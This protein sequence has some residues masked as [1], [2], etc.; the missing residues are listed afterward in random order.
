MPTTYAH[1][2]FGIKVLKELNKEL[3]ESIKNNIDL[4]NIGLHGPDILFYYK[5]L[6][7]N[8]INMLGS[9]IHETNADIFFENSRRTILKSDDFN[10]AFA[11]IAGFICHYVLDSECHP[12][13]RQKESTVS[14]N[15][16]ETEFDREIMIKDNL[17]PITFKPTSHITPSYENAKCISEFFP[18]TLTE[19][20]LKSLKS[21]KF[22]LNALV[23]PN[24]AVRALLTGALKI[25]GNRSKA[26]LIKKYSP[27]EKCSEINHELYKL[28]YEAIKPCAL[29]IDE[30]YRNIKTN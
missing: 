7:S 29:L 22:Y 8:K 24:P 4:Y 9:E 5:P 11:Y 10:K 13:I 19:E 27:N 25:T 2:T 1:Y 14:H 12:Y 3:N 6:K 23:V 30:Y 20:I 21:M 15:E 17:N 28:Y 18:G 16:I 26:D